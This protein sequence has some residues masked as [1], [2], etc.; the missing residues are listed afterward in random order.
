MKYLLRSDN[1]EE[2]KDFSKIVDN[3]NYFKGRITQENYA[4]VLEGLS[5]L[6]FVEISLERDKDDPQRI[7]ESLN[8][9]GLELSQADLFRN[10]ILMGLTRKHQQKIYENYWEVIRETG[11][12]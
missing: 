4:F 11:K 9:T 1:D 6:L 12:R 7:F 2:F 5:K 10:F 8:S 3:F